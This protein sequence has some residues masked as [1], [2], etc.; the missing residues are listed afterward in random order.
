VF[1]SSQNINFP[2]YLRRLLELSFSLF[3]NTF[4]SSLSLSFFL[5]F[6]SWGLRGF[7][8]IRGEKSLLQK[9]LFKWNGMDWLSVN[10]S[11]GCIFWNGVMHANMAKPWSWRFGSCR[12]IDGG[13]IFQSGG[14]HADIHLCLHVCKVIHLSLKSSDPFHRALCLVNPITNIPLQRSIPVRVPSRGGGFG[15]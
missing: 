7:Y 11:G 6:V 2:F 10:I 4:S 14:M 15:S 12:Y 9:L 1:F 8:D 3:F 13:R 5:C